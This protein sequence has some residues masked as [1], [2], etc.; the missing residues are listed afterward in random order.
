[1]SHI[2]TVALLG[3][4]NVGKTTLFNALT[5]LR[6][7]TA[8]Y[9]GVTVEKKWG[10]LKGADHT[11]IFDLPGAYSLHPQSP[12]EEIV[13][14]VL[15]G[16]Q[17]GAEKPDLI[18]IVM[19]ANNFSRNLY[20]AL[21]VMASGL[22]AI[23]VL[24]MW[25]EAQQSG[26]QIDLEQIKNTFGLETVVTEGALGIGIEGLRR[27]IT[28]G[29]NQPRRPVL[30]FDVTS[31][32]PAEIYQKVDELT[33]RFVKEPGIAVKTL[34]HKID[35]VLTHPF[36][37]WIIFCAVMAVIFQSI[38]SWATPLMD[39][40]S[41]GVD[42]VGRFAAN[43]LPDGQLESL[44]VDGVIAGVGNVIVF[45]PQ[46]FLLFF[47]IAFFE[48]FGYMAR[49]AFVLDRLMKKVGLNGKAFLPLLS[50]FACAIPG[51]MAARTIP[52]KNDRIAT[53]MTAPLMSC[54]ARLP[55]YALMIG[56]FIPAEKV[57]GIFNL[58]GV[59]LFAMYFLSIFAGLTVAAI[60]KKTLLKG[61]RTPFLLEM[62]P[63]RVPRF[64]NVLLVM[65]DRGREFIKNAGTT[66]FVLSIILW[67]LA[68]YPKSSDI[69]FRYE[70]QRKD[71]AQS[72][73]ADDLKTKL[74][75]IDHEEASEQLKA[76]FAGKLG[77]FIEPVIRPLGFD[78][79]IGIGLVSSFAAREV[80]VSTLAIIYNV[81]DEADEN[82]VDLMDA[83]R[84]EKDPV[85]GEPVYTPLVAVG[86]MV[87]FVLACQC[88]STVAIVKRET[89]GWGWPLF[90]VGYMTVLA[91]LG[92]FAVHQIGKLLGF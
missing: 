59:T 52:D 35:D 76:S 15:E 27:A 65:W 86:I 28:A 36:F 29:L 37:G 31:K 62:P 54:S 33:A 46:I 57:F 6:H 44:V 19:D 38:F 51:I 91:W 4:P 82:S 71:A 67:F 23:L 30:P 55:V 21:Q 13:R 39:L 22:P 45:V 49:A 20:F 81:G 87:F 24:N 25:D 34:S 85:T 9:P 2:Q 47:F 32:T 66:I 72:M 50:S 74:H 60:F 92:A 84:K 12:D 80:L 88:M 7:T 78:W 43:I 42:M 58:K 73:Q 18:V 53:I 8:N 64:Q 5:G 10:R 11:D 17:D 48:D 77:H 90:M 3:N 75:L 40:I 61:N 83:L 41:N 69:A 89:G 14:N 68:S 26:K 70:V 56:A 63:Y 79:K 16:K 1:M